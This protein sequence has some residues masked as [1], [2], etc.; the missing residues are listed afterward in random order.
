M[1]NYNCYTLFKFIKYITEYEDNLI[2]IIKSFLIPCKNDYLFQECEF[3]KK[4]MYEVSDHEHHS[5]SFLNSK[6]K[7]I[8]C[9][10][11]FNRKHKIFS[12]LKRRKSSIV[13]QIKSLEYA[14]Y[15]SGK[16]LLRSDAVGQWFQHCAWSL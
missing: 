16:P 12:S 9:P 5:D 3:V 4:I 7:Q 10:C 14:S 6:Y 1:N 13:V 15:E 11:Y 8:Y 2:P